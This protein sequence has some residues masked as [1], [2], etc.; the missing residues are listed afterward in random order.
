MV[1]PQA[2]PENLLAEGFEMNELMRREAFKR[3]P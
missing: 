1:N 3:S 2:C